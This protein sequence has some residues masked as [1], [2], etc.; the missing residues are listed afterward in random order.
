MTPTTMGNLDHFSCMGPFGV[1]KTSRYAGHFEPN[2][3]AGGFGIGL[4]GV[5]DCEIQSYLNPWIKQI[6]HLGFAILSRVTNPVLT[7]KA[8]IVSLAPWGVRNSLFLLLK[9]HHS[10]S[11]WTPK[12]GMGP[13]FV[14]LPIPWLHTSRECNGSVPI[15]PKAVVFDSRALLCSAEAIFGRLLTP[16]GQIAR[17]HG[18]RVSS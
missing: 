17:T 14:G 12:F 7:P 8:G 4:C 6:S 3:L 13:H 15:R 1:S 2:V 5:F 18:L 11:K 9:N 10:L 16:E